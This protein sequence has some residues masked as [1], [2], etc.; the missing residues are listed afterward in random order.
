MSLRLSYAP[1]LTSPLVL[2]EFADTAELASFL[3]SQK[4]VTNKIDSAIIVPA[5]FKNY[6]VQANERTI[7]N[8]LETTACI[9]DYDAGDVTAEEIAEK[10]DSLSLDYTIR[11]SF[12]D[13]PESPRFCAIIPWSQPLAVGKHRAAVEQIV[14]P[15]LNGKGHFANESCVPTQARF[16][17]PK[18]G[19]TASILLP[20]A[21]PWMLTNIEV[22][23]SLPAATPATQNADPLAL[24]DTDPGN[25][26]L[27]R[28]ALN[29]IDA[30]KLGR[31]WVAV[32]GCGM[33]M[34]GI[35]PEVL[36][37]KE[38][39][40][41]QWGLIADLEAFSA[42]GSQDKYRNPENGIGID[43]C[44]A[45]RLN[46]DG[47]WV[48]SLVMQNAST[49]LYGTNMIT[50]TGVIK[51]SDFFAFDSELQ[52]DFPELLE[53]A[54]Q[55]FH[56]D[57]VVEEALPT[58][59]Q[60]AAAALDGERR[61]A[62]FNDENADYFER[63]NTLLDRMPK[64][65]A[66]RLAH[67]LATGGVPG[68]A[69]W[70]LQPPAAVV[71]GA[72]IINAIMANRVWLKMANLPALAGNLYAYM[73]ADSGTGKSVMVDY[74]M[75][76]LAKA[77]Y[78][79]AHYDGKVHSASG[80]HTNL[81]SRGPTLLLTADE[82]KMW[83]SNVEGNAQP[84][85]N[86]ATLDAFMLN[87]WLASSRGRKVTPDV[88]A[89]DRNGERVNVAPPIR[90]P[91][92]STFMIG[93]PEDMHFFSEGMLSDGSLARSLCFVPTEDTAGETDEQRTRRHAK[94][95]EEMRTGTGE[96]LDDKEKDAAIAALIAF[97]KAL[98]DQGLGESRASN[99]SGHDFIEEQEAPALRDEM[100]AFREFSMA[101]ANLPDNMIRILYCDEETLRLIGKFDLE[102]ALRFPSRKVESIMNRY[103]E[104][105]ERL[106]LCLTVFDN[107]AA[108]KINYDHMEF[109]LNLV[110][111]A[112]EPWLKR[113]L[114]AKQ[115]ITLKGNKFEKFVPEIQKLLEK[116][117]PLHSKPAGFSMFEIKCDKRFSA[118]QSVV[119]KLKVASE[120]I[121]RDAQTT[122]D[123]LNLSPIKNPNG[124]GERIFHPD[125]RPELHDDN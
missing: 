77:G 5:V 46:G 110:A 15:L 30:D 61:I 2:K 121:R 99:L 73:F 71:L 85:S 56:H 19:T 117:G 96:V 57:I 101:R 91:N 9:L 7:I 58:E 123:A 95:R 109:A 112:E 55:R 66:Q 10:L 26:L 47:E 1:S 64:G 114:D 100:T 94:R 115:E 69:T 74:A 118:L 65:P 104:K 111:L 72:M 68:R 21:D 27:F 35:T 76:I 25:R 16:I 124:K 41:E 102:F 59:E 42:R 38:L 39:T 90:Q 28:L 18:V 107:P 119:S 78:E 120:A 3:A 116:G 125:H 105:A 86:Q 37:T 70:F 34:F 22:P 8:A 17:Q 67:T 12:S 62:K 14:K 52:T 83:F 48:P 82:L 33:R 93:V 106:A 79:W 81:M 20:D 31:D 11:P 89:A 97:D 53:Q 13:T 51:R 36:K 80:M 98:Q 54:R 50:L 29:Y 23:D 88:R 45:T 84:N 87:V 6:P 60:L 49:C 103:A 122:L 108:T 32:L 75:E 40:T 113:L 44:R 63:V 4:P 92:I 43:R 24:V